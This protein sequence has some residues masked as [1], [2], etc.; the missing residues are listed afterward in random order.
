MNFNNYDSIFDITALCYSS[1]QYRREI[2]IKSCKLDKENTTEIIIPEGVEI[3]DEYAFINFVKLKKI[4]FPSTI[5]SICKGAFE[6]CKSL[7]SIS[8]SNPVIIN[9]DAFRFCDSLKYVEVRFTNSRKYSV[10]I[11]NSPHQMYAYEPWELPACLIFDSDK[12]SIR[13]GAFKDC[14]T[15]KKIKLCKQ[16]RYFQDESL[17]NVKI[18]G[19]TKT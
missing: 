11:K 14:P 7:E 13:K 9:P 12:G 2:G 17:Y 18:I 16:M 1:N 10:L 15:L 4:T 5:T 3:I 8:F 6:C 19:G